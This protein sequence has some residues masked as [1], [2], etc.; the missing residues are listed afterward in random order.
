M[1]V[2]HLSVTLQVWRY[3][4]GGPKPTEFLDRLVIAPGDTVKKRKT[5][6]RRVDVTAIEIGE[7]S[8]AKEPREAFVEELENRL[9]RAADWLGKQ[10]P[11]VFAT[12]RESGFYTDLL[13]T[14]WID[15]DQLDLDLPPVLLEA[16]GKLG[17]KISIITND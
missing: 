3:T 14:G 5:P 7:F 16:C 9:T 1:A 8:D 10:P 15:C 4:G 13:F 11:E 6:N 17:L 2:E 12:L